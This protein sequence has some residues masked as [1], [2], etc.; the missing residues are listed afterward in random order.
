M[1]G[2]WFASV[3]LIIALG[4]VAGHMRRFDGRERA[5]LEPL[6]GQE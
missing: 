3:G 1:W 2:H 6:R 4:L 5:P